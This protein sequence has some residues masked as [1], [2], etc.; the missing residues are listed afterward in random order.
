MDRQPLDV[1]ALRRSLCH[2]DGPLARLDVV[3]T[4]ESTSSE[5]AAR[6]RAGDV[7]GPAALVAEHQTA[8]RG[9]AGRSW[10]TPPRAALTVSFA[11][12]PEVP[13]S[14]LGWIPLVTGLAVVRTLAV[15]G[16]DAR[17]KWPNDALLPAATP[18]EGLGS[19]RKV[20]GVLA[21]VVPDAGAPAARTPAIVVGA[22]INVSQTADELP[23]PTATSLA[24]AGAAAD[25]EALLVGLARELADVVGRLEAAAGDAVASGL[26][27]EYAAVSA[28]LGARVRA[29]LAGGDDVVVG[30]AD[31]VAD[32]GALVLATTGG[33][34]VVTAGDVHHLRALP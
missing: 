21:E 23:V 33:E 5:L 20:G 8:G 32:D 12:R 25:R 11:L 7:R 29:E 24:L 15:L 18:V 10:Q 2:T 6:V 13:S 17:L 27:A 9:R 26:A 22:G 1:E 30:R 19:H 3:A 4:T 34:R 28:T 31:R 16:C 14:A